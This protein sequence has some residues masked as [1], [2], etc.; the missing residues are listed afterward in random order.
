MRVQIQQKK[1][2]G[3][4][5]RDKTCTHRTPVNGCPETTS[6]PMINALRPQINTLRFLNLNGCGS[7]TCTMAPRYMEPKTKTCVTLALCVLSHTQIITCWVFNWADVAIGTVLSTMSPPTVRKSME[8]S[9]GS[10]KLGKKKAGQARV[11]MGWLA[12]IHVYIYIYIHI[13]IY[14]YTG[15]Y[16]QYIYIYI[17]I[18]ICWLNVRVQ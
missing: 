15:K 1:H 12:H 8:S 16:I 18:A 2:K 5:Q 13:Y 11:S 17:H 6:N 10:R 9:L 4:C 14:V 3:H 7:E